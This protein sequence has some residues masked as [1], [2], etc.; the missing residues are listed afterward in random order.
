MWS[1]HTEKYLITQKCHNLDKFWHQIYQIWTHI[2]RKQEDEQVKTPKKT[3][4]RERGYVKDKYGTGECNPFKPE[5]SE[6]NFFLNSG[7]KLKNNKNQVKLID[8]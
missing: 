6:A 3:Y 1:V 7:G 8:R 4:R 2:I 5:Q